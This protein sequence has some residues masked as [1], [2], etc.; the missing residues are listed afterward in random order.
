MQAVGKPLILIGP[1]LGVSVFNGVL[2]PVIAALL[3]EC[4]CNK[5]HHFTE[6]YAT[7]SPISD[8]SVSGSIIS[9]FVKWVSKGSINIVVPYF[10]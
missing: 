7:V 3:G 1:T 5:S 6:Y 10:M 8:Q 4:T 9:N 2:L